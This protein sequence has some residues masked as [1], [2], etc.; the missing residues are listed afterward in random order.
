MSIKRIGKYEILEE[1]GRGGMAVVYKAKDTSLGREVAL[2]LLHPYLAQD[3]QARIRLESEARAVARLKHPLIPEVYD[4]SGSKSEQAYIVTEF[5]SGITLGQFFEKHKLKMAESA[6][7][8]FYQITLALQHAH[9]N[10]IIHRDIK[11]DNIMIT[12][13]GKIKLM[14]FGI[15]RVIE[16]PGITSTGQIL[17]SPA[18]MSPEIIKGKPAGK[19]SDIFSLGILLYQLS[20]GESP[21]YGSNTHAVLVKIAEVEYEDPEA[22]KPDMGVHCANLIRSCLSREPQNRPE[23]VALLLSRIEKI[24][25]W[26][27]IGK[28]DFNKLSSK[29]LLDPENTDEE[30]KPEIVESLIKIAEEEGKKPLGQQIISRLLYLAPDEEEVKRIW[31]SSHNSQTKLKKLLLKTVSLAILLLIILFIAIYF[32][33]LSNS[34]TNSQSETAFKLLSFRKKQKNIKKNNQNNFLPLSTQDYFEPPISKMQDATQIKIDHN[35][36][37]TKKDKN[38]TKHLKKLIHHPKI[39][40]D[41]KKK[42]RTFPSDTRSF[43][44]LP[45]PQGQIKLFLDGKY[46]GQWGPRPPAISEIKPGPGEHKITLK[47]PLCYSKTI[48][49]DKDMN[50]RKINIRLK[51]RPARVLVK[52]SKNNTVAIKLLEGKKRTIPGMP[53]STIEIAFPPLWNRSQI[54]AKVILVNEKNNTTREIKINLKAGQLVKQKIK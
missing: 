44:L 1:V 39:R 15:S 32:F 11:P 7:L 37:K 25:S 29:L 34:K 49:I 41:N 3:E 30:I 52:T 40:I 9:E 35:S 14:D 6:L 38:R 17:G 43:Q 16:N 36:K 24:L 31:L 27:G 26:S 5:I 23:N 42:L 45:F 33:R 19:K 54:K 10:G 48:K 53:N 47:H 21:F 50:S 4:Y 28:E 2:K 46:L 18:Y 8:I 13:E 20:T 22:K 51:W 12:H